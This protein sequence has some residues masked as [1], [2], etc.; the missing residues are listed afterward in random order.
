MKSGQP[1]RPR[2]APLQ[3]MVAFG[4]YGP[5]FVGDLKKINANVHAGLMP[6][7]SIVPGDVPAFA[8]GE[9]V[10]W[11][12]WKSSLNSDA[13]KQFVAFYARP[14]NVARV[15]QADNLP[16]GLNTVNVDL[17]D[18]GGYYQKYS[19]T[20]V[21]PYFNRAYLPDGMWNIL[22]KNG[23][24]ILAGA[25][26]PGQYSDNVGKEFYRLRASKLG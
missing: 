14:E 3:G 15:A 6:I 19:A 8:G 5:Y 2:V 16:P 17:G 26:T 10:T 22:C 25:I 23:Q 18:L 9:G 13:A 7:P 12:V 21:F 1:E 20:P 24:D 4:I 11:G